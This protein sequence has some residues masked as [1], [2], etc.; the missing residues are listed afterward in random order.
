MSVSSVLTKDELSFLQE[1]GRFAV[2]ADFKGETVQLSALIE[3]GTLDYLKSI[4]AALHA[5][6]NDVTGS[7]LM[8]R[9]A[10]LAVNCLFSMTAFNKAIDVKPE[11]IWI[12]STVNND[13]WLPK[14]RFKEL[15][16]VEAPSENR[17]A[18]RKEIF[19]QLFQEVYAPLIEQL[20]KDAKVS[21]Q[22]LWEN[23]MLY[24]YWLYETVL[25]KLEQ[26]TY[27]EEDFQSLLKASPHMFEMKRNPASQFYK[28]KTFVQK[29]QAEIRVRTTCCFYYRANDAGAH[30][31]TCPLDCK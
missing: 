23:V 21:R 31:S 25:P 14:I 11:N 28:E 12:D 19:V 7:L 29:H 24:I 26:S 16:V 8:K 30:C 20:K 9:L 4:Q 5:E 10:F 17:E 3:N 6:K 15:K 1:N 13:I 22:T 27:L 18:W 2:G